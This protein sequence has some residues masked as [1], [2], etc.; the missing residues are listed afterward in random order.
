MPLVSAVTRASSAASVQRNFTTVSAE[1]A[2]P[3]YFAT[4]ST[5]GTAFPISPMSSPKK[6]EPASAAVSITVDSVSVIVQGRGV[7]AAAAKRTGSAGAKPPPAAFLPS[8]QTSAWK[9]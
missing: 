7:A 4:F 5:P 2:R 9:R 8:R 3:P 1:F 6:V